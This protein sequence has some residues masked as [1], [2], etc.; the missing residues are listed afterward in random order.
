MT[1]S[2]I[3][4]QDQK[5]SFNH[6][7]RQEEIYHL[8]TCTVLY[9]SCITPHVHYTTMPHLIMYGSMFHAIHT[10]NISCTDLPHYLLEDCVLGSNV[11]G[12][13]CIT[14]QNRRR[15]RKEKGVPHNS[16][17]FTCTCTC[18]RWSA[19]RSQQSKASALHLDLIGNGPR[20]GIAQCA[21]AV[22]FAPARS[23]Q[24]HGQ[25]GR[26]DILLQFLLVVAAENVNLA[27]GRFV[28]PW[29]HEGPYGRK[30]V[31]GLGGRASARLT[32]GTM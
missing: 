11:Y 12:M 20:T 3:K 4:N 9:T 21:P 7:H 25:V 27:Y 14:K 16:D 31:W 29:F 15:R 10:H 22:L 13:G 26:V 32:H 19:V 17:T 30:E 5:Q 23:A 28:Q 24:V 18:L 1:R 2:R 6:A 8:F